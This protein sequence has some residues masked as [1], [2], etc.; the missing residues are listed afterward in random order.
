LNKD[1][2]GQQ[3]GQF[4]NRGQHEPTEPLSSLGERDASNVNRRNI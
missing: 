2:Q 1:V 4:G 3:Q